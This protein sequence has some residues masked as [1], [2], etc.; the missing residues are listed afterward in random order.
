MGGGT[1]RGSE[2]ETGL[3]NT[4]SFGASLFLSNA[5]ST[6]EYGDGSAILESGLV[7]D[8]TLYGHD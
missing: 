3:A 6:A 7:T 5:D 1:I 8:E 2:A 4:A